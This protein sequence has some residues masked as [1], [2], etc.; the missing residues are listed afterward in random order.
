M[1]LAKDESGEMLTGM[2][3]RQMALLKCIY[4]NAYSTGNKQEQL[5]A[6][7]QQANYDLIAITET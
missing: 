6:V 1:R 7:M 2:R 5:E 4:T 3:V